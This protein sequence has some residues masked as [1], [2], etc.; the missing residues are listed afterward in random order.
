[1]TNIFIGI[2]STFEK[3]GKAIKHGITT[4]RETLEHVNNIANNAKN[5]VNSLQNTTPKLVTP[6]SQTESG[7]KTMLITPRILDVENEEVGLPQEPPRELLKFGDVMDAVGI[8]NPNGDKLEMEKIVFAPTGPVII[9]DNVPKQYKV[10][11]PRLEKMLKKQDKDLTKM[12]NAINN[13]EQARQIVGA[14]N[15]RNYVLQMKQHIDL[16]KRISAK[17]KIR[18]KKRKGSYV[19]RKGMY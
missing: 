14:P 13:L 4:G 18:N 19:K 5:A 7:G 15:L 9:R 17:E 1:M 2:M 12:E 8:S 11:S 6:L 16:I 3:M 10:K